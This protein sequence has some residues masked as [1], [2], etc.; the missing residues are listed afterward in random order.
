MARMAHSDGTITITLNGE[1]KRVAA[2]LSI[3]SLAE[4]LGLVPAKLAVGRHL[5]GV[6]RATRGDGPGGGSAR[7]KS[8]GW[9]RG[10]QWRC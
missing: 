10:L 9:R 4:S 1:H 2:G 8:G 7:G 3:A 5:P 6:A